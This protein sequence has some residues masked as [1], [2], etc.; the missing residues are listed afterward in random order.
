[1]ADFWGSAHAAR[2]ILMAGAA[3]WALAVSG[4]ALA[5]HTISGNPAGPVSSSHVP[6]T[7]RGNAGTSAGAADT[8]EINRR[9]AAAAAAM[10]D[11]TRAADAA[12][13]KIEADTIANNAKYEAD[14]AAYRRKLAEDKAKADR[15]AADYAARMADYRACVKGDKG[16]CARD[17]ASRR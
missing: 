11:D 3:A 2:R 5:Q 12:R 15:A 9:A 13:R 8:A 6:G 4:T 14:M 7:A 17:L 1:M 10:T 16:A